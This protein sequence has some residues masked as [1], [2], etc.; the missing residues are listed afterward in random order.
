M[1]GGSGRELTVAVDGREVARLQG[2]NTPGQW[3]PGG[4]VELAAGSHQLRLVR[5]G[6][7]LAPGDGYAAEIGPV[8]LEPVREPQPVTVTPGRA[9]ATFC[10]RRW[11]WI[12]RIRP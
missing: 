8:T 7:N 11:D 5:P 2:V 1:R 4:E 6:G 10:G 3:L 12:E 9:E